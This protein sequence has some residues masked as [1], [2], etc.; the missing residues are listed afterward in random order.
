MLSTLIQ[1]LVG[2]T[3]EQRRPRKV[4]GRCS[5]KGTVEKYRKALAGAG[6][7]TIQEV[8]QLTGVRIG[9]LHRTVEALVEQGY[10]EKKKGPPALFNRRPILVR[11]L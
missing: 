1:Q 11:W 7:C 6:W 3:D 8:S 10:L 9:G 2:S 4:D 5:H